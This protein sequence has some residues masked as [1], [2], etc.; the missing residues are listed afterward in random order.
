M[1]AAN[2]WILNALDV[3][4]WVLFDTEEICNP[5]LLG[6][7][8]I[9][10]A[11]KLPTRLEA[12]EETDD[13]AGTD[14]ARPDVRDE[15]GEP[16]E[17]PVVRDDAG[18]KIPILLETCNVV[19]PSTDEPGDAEKDNARFDDEDGTL[20]ALLREL[21]TE[22]TTLLGLVLGLA[23]DNDVRTLA[24]ECPDATVRDEIGLDVIPLE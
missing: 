19:A 7:L 23:E 16:E 8:E 20:K 3:L 6:I 12:A 13:R 9:F 2:E 18:D 5:L 21:K 24:R 10:N 11:D 22:D 14:A 17:G 15:A 4:L 1:A